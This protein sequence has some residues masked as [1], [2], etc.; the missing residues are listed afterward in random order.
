VAQACASAGGQ[1]NGAA[2]TM[3]EDCR[4][5]SCRS[6]ACR[7]AALQGDA[8]QAPADCAVGTCCASGAQAQT[9]ALSCD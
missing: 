8:C 4:S 7:G 6:G 3:N 9:C 2:C 5:Q 1:P